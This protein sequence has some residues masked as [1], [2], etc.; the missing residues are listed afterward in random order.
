MWSNQ[1]FMWTLTAFKSCDD[2]YGNHHQLWQPSS[3]QQHCKPSRFRSTHHLWCEGRGTPAQVLSLTLQVCSI[4]YPTSVCVM[5]V[6]RIIDQ[7][8]QTPA[9]VWCRQM[10]HMTAHTAARE[11]EEAC[12]LKSGPN[13]TQEVTSQPL[14]LWKCFPLCELV[15]ERRPCERWS[16]C[17]SLFV[18]SQEFVARPGFRSSCRD[19]ILLV[20]VTTLHVL[21][22]EF[23]YTFYFVVKISIFK[24]P[25]SSLIPSLTFRFAS[26]CWIMC[27]TQT[28][29]LNIKVHIKIKIANISETLMFYFSVSHFQC[30]NKPG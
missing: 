12:S 27:Y 26:L 19:V 29:Q 8:I 6:S 30:L 14:L 28:A 3:G 20:A 1:Y 10:C 15:H 22:G 9:K 2:C 4:W 13:N 11:E 21:A 25:E 17:W 24:G 18:G 5:Y 7:K 16:L 23:F